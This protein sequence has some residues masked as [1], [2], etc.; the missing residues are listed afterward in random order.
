[1]PF[2]DGATVPVQLSF[3]DALESGSGVS[4]NKNEDIAFVITNYVTN[5]TPDS[6]IE[7]HDVYEAPKETE[8]K[9]R[10]V[11]RFREELCE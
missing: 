1:M 5:L 2:P 9:D 3:L 6:F 11:S 4:A 7:D 10:R 8:K